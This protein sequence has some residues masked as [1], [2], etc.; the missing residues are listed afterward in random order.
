VAICKIKEL[1]Y[2]LQVRFACSFITMGH[3][4]HTNGADCRTRDTPCTVRG[5]RNFV[6]LA[7]HLLH[8]STF[9]FQMDEAIKS[10]KIAILDAAMSLRPS[11]ITTPP[12]SAKAL[13]ERLILDTPVI[14]STTRGLQRVENSATL[15]DSIIKKY[16]LD[17][18]EL[19]ICSPLAQPNYMSTFIETSESDLATPLE[20]GKSEPMVQTNRVHFDDY[21][22]ILSALPCGCAQD[23][24]CRLVCSKFPDFCVCQ[25]RQDPLGASP[26]RLQP[27]YRL[28]TPPLSGK[29]RNRATHSPDKS[30][31]RSPSDSLDGLP[32]TPSKSPGYR[33]R[34]KAVQ[35][36]SAPL[37]R[38]IHL[39][40]HMMPKPPQVAPAK[41]PSHYSPFDAFEKEK[42]QPSLSSVLAELSSAK[43]HSLPPTPQPKP[44][45][46]SEPVL[47]HRPPLRQGKTTS[48]VISYRVPFEDNK[49]FQSNRSSPTPSP[50]RKVRYVSAGG[51]LPFD[52][53]PTVEL[54]FTKEESVETDFL[55]PREPTVKQKLV[56]SGSKS[57]E[58]KLKRSKSNR[59][60]R[61]KCRLS[62]LFER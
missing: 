41:S 57:P 34:S 2:D 6:C 58:F 29:Y 43:K 44:N 4:L 62:R 22:N 49:F 26:D 38:G 23:C 45:R 10:R 25:Y 56:H 31:M 13:T 1:Y 17:S 9:R 51:N 55:R 61:F 46:N 5:F 8:D 39:D 53:R 24:D 20:A 50:S 32:V 21:G 36:P 18:Y 60:S 47:H 35:S 7:W 11:D 33:L 48:Q 3:I 15:L 27:N 16:Q 42:S 14:R 30:I 37:L 28:Q 40:T 59:V 12:D 19:P 52:K 54:P